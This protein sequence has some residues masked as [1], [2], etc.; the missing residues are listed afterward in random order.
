MLNNKSRKKK[1]GMSFVE[2]Q[3][4]LFSPLRSQQESENFSITFF[5]DAV[6]FITILS[7][8]TTC[9]CSIDDRG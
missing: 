9:A 4:S 8:K 1:S 3:S 7:I 2:I 5:K 6:N